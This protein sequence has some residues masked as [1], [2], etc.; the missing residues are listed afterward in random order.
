MLRSTTWSA[1]R[2]PQNGRHNVKSHAANIRAW[3]DRATERERAEGRAWYQAAHAECTMLATEHMLP[4]ETVAAIVAVLSPAL[5]WERNIA[6]ARAVIT[7]ESTSAYGANVRKA[8]RLLAGEP[9]STVVSG[10]KVTAFYNLLRD[11]SASNELVLDSI[12]VLLALGRD[13]A[14]VTNE[15]AKPTLGRPRVMRAI[16]RAY[17]KVAT[18]LGIL[19]HELQATTWVTWRNERDNA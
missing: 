18:D 5:R 6:A 15:D 16:A 11:P 3:Y 9:P 7:G 13:P 12:A 4:I 17:R 19:P 14:L 10:P 8:Q 2:G 1:S